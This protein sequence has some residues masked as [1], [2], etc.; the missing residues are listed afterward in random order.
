MVDCQSAGDGRLWVERRNDVA[1]YQGQF[2]WYELMTTDTAAAR[3]F[4][5]KVVGWGVEDAST[6]GLLTLRLL[7]AGP[8]SP[9]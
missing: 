1:D 8:R 3:A 6:P 9:A 2:A 5:A 4:Y 7:L